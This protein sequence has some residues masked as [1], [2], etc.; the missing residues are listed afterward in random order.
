MKNLFDVYFSQ[1]IGIHHCQENQEPDLKFIG[2]IISKVIYGELRT[3]GIVHDL[4]V[5]KGDYTML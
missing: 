2:F 3:F 1:Y 4:V 5:Q